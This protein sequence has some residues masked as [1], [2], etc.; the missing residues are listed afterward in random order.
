MIDRPT[1]VV[2]TASWPC[3]ATKSTRSARHLRVGRRCEVGDQKP[4]VSGTRMTVIQR[5]GSRSMISVLASVLPGRPRLCMRA[6]SRTSA[7][8][9]LRQ[10]A[11]AAEAARAVAGPRQ[12]RSACLEATAP[13]P[14]AELPFCTPTRQCASRNRTRVALVGAASMQCYVPRRERQRGRSY[15]GS[16]QVTGLA[17]SDRSAASLTAAGLVAG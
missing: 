10:L 15:V 2:S 5:E 4:S 3:R 8:S 14:H 17:R 7:P 13:I 6:C 12:C 11:S 1:S 9:A 16:H